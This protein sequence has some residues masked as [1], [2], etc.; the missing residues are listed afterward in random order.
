MSALIL[1]SHVKGTEL[2]QKYKLGRE[3][4]D[5]IRQHHGTRVMRFFYQRP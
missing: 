3:I 2:A 5:I 1:F 4:T